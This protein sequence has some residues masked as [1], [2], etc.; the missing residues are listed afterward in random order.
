MILRWRTRIG[1]RNWTISSPTRRWGLLEIAA[2]LNFEA[3]Q[4]E[5]DK[6]AELFRQLHDDRKKPLG[7]VFVRFWLLFVGFLLSIL[8]RVM[9]KRGWNKDHRAVGRER[10]EHEESRFSVGTPRGGPSSKLFKSFLRGSGAVSMQEY[11]GNMSRK[12][13]KEDKMKAVDL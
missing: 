6:T 10:E 7:A 4:M 3:K 11:A 9:R 13:V 8:Y 5:L 12:K 2:R 1:G